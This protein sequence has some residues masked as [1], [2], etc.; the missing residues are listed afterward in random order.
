MNF[1]T[2]KLLSDVQ[3]ILQKVVPMVT[4]PD[5]EV[6]RY[7]QFY[8]AWKENTSYPNN[9][10]VTYQH[11]FYRVV[12]DEMTPVTIPED[13]SEPQI[14]PD[15]FTNMYEVVQNDTDGVYPYISPTSDDTTYS[16]GEKVTYANTIWESLVD[17]NRSVPGLDDG[18]NWKV[19]VSE[20]NKETAKPVTEDTGSTGTESIN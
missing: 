3:S 16:K 12:G 14:T 19:Y 20:E 8:P 4:I 7:E 9:S 13:G 18:T 17:S 2:V 6:S 11:K 10:I 1:K 15:E 5:D